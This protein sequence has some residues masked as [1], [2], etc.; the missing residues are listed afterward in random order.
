VIGEVFPPSFLVLQG[1]IMLPVWIVE[2]S[3][4]FGLG[5]DV[6]GI[7]ARDHVRGTERL[8]RKVVNLPPVAV[9]R[10][11][12]GN[13]LRPGEDLLPKCVGDGRFGDSTVNV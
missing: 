9:V 10:D 7:T 12:A 4:G 1:V 13:V 11:L 6:S 5:A 2:F 8:K 3:G